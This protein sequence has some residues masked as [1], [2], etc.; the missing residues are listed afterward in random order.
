MKILW[1]ACVLL[2]GLALAPLANAQES[3]PAR[4]VRI[5]VGFGAG[6]ISDVMAR[7]LSVEL[8]KTWGQPVV[9]E[10]KPGASGVIGAELVAK[11]PADGYV[12][13][14]AS[15]TH[16]ITP[17]LRLKMPYDAVRDFTAITL[18]A[19]AP[20]MLVVNADTA[21]RSVAD[22]IAAAKAKPGE[23][24][25]ATSG[26]GTTVHIAGERLAHLAGVR[27]N[28][29]PY[30]S[31]SQSVE[32]VVAGQVMSSWSAV[33]AALPHIKS[34]RV[35]A[36]AVASEKRSSFAPDV[37]TFEELGVKGMKSDTWLGM[38]GPP[39]MPAAVATKINAEL[40]RLL[41]RPDFR[42]KVLGLGA[43]PVAGVALEKYSALMRDEIDSYA[44]IIKVANIKP[45]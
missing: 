37:P 17:A 5:I 21:F 36:L 31:S 9:V 3:Y 22:Y 41:V 8:Q 2:A 6:G 34:G 24:N 18:L 23:V 35:R 45:E 4:P 1:H 44:A 14:L 33:N 29:I 27:L 26:I 13:M 38:L 19:S 40:A 7:L 11:S 25:Y 42:E 43:E 16:T 10:N 30:R 12:L 39:N 20:N 15:G 28:H 32:A